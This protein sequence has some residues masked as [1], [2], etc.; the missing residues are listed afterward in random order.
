MGMP[1][2]IRQNEKK[3][4]RCSVCGKIIKER[5]IVIKTCCV[6]KPWYFCSNICYHKW[7]VIWLR[8]QEQLSG[9]T[10]RRYSVI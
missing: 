8:R 6:N 9:G 7:R 1:F 5:P 10:L 3:L 2:E 4:L